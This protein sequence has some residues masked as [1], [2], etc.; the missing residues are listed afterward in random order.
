M[1]ISILSL[2]EGAKQAKGITVIIDVFRA[3]TLE[4]YLFSQGAKEIIAVSKEETARQLKQQYEDY[5][6]IGERKGKKLPGF[7]YGNSPSSIH[8]KSFEGKTIIHTTTNGIQGINNAKD[9]TMILTGAFVNAKA[10][11]NYIK[12]QNPDFVSL[13]AMGW[14]ERRTEEDEL[15]AQ[16]L[17]DLLEGK[18]D[19][20]INE[21]TSD[22]RYYEGKKF[23]DEAQQEAFPKDDFFDCIQTNIFDFVIKVEKKDDLMICQKVN[24]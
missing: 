15:C 19:C 16:Y 20:K 3:F 23:F 17:K 5:I 1:E 14:E 13:V 22:L 2:K 10:T 8:N 12:K 11:A 6:L 7:D 4:A 18:E 21:K 24:V 9:A